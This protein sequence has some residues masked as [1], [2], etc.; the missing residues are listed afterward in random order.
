MQAFKLSKR[1]HQASGL[2][3][4][5]V[6]DATLKIDVAGH[7][8]NYDAERQLWYCDMQIDAGNTY[9]PFIRLALVRYQ[10]NSL[11]W[12]VTGPDTVV[13]HTVIMSIFRL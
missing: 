8:V 6:P 13:D 7:E 4:A 3:L 9:Y 2:L 5:E 12:S 10:P 11:S 1:E